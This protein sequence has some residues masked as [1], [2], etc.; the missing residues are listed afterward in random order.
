MLLIWIAIKVIQGEESD[1]VPRMAFHFS[2]FS[3]AASPALP[4]AYYSVLLHT[5][6]YLW[7]NISSN[8]APIGAAVSTSHSPLLLPLAHSTFPASLPPPLSPSQLTIQWGMTKHLPAATDSIGLFA[9]NASQPH[10]TLNGL[11]FNQTL[12]QAQANALWWYNF[13]SITSASAGNVS[14]TAPNVVGNYEFRFFSNF[15]A[16][17]VAGL[18]VCKSCVLQVHRGGVVCFVLCEL[19]I[20]FSAVCMM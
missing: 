10:T 19:L 9:I 12:A 17:A 7:L 5:A 6:P 11:P 14:L 4:S 18:F 8:V 20:C 2:L 1:F 15:S 3:F 13:S 16:S